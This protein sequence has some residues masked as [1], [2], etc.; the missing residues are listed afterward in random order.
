MAAAMRYGKEL[1]R[2]GVCDMPLTNEESRELGIGPVCRAK[3][4]AA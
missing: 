4:A 3:L 1:G 2:C